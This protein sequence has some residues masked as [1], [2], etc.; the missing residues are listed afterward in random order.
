MQYKIK[1][2]YRQKR[3]GLEAA[4]KLWNSAQAAAAN[5]SPM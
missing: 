1:A 2:I 3:K 5:E 4:N